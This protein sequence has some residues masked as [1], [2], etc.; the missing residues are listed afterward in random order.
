MPSARLGVGSPRFARPGAKS[1]YV[2]LPSLPTATT[3]TLLVMCV[4]QAHF[5]ITDGS[6]KSSWA[7]QPLNA[8]V[9]DWLAAGRLTPTEVAALASPSYLRTEAEVRAALLAVQSMWKVER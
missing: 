5:P 1:F 6:P 9:V 3:Y 8:V 2:L 7:L 4:L